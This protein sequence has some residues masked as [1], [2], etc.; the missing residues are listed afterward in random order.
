MRSA[1]SSA[2]DE[3][4]AAEAGQLLMLIQLEQVGPRNEARHAR[5]IRATAVG[6]HRAVCSVR[7]LAPEQRNESTPAPTGTF[8]ASSRSPF[9]GSP[10]DQA[11]AERA[12]R[13]TRGHELPF[14]RS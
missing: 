3:A 2:P 9:V 7:V 13:L 5:A 6:Q 1:R 8:L 12:G 4:L 10:I 14:G 11:K